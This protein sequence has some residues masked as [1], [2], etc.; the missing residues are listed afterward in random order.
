MTTND[1]APERVLDGIGATP[2]AGVGSAVWYDSSVAGSLSEP[3]DPGSVTPE[4][5]RERFREAREATRRELQAEREAIAERLGED[6]AEI[7]DAHREFLDDPQITEAVDGR[8]DEGLPAEHAVNHAF[9]GAIEQFEAAGGLAAERT[10]DL[11][12]VRN[13]LL[14]T[15]LGAEAPDLADLPPGSIVVA[16]RLG[17]ADTVQ[18]DPDRVAGF[19][20]ATGGR[21]SHAAVM[22]RSLGLPAVVGVGDE[23]TTVPDGDVIVVD[24]DDGVVVVNPTE[25]RQAAARQRRRRVEV[26]HG[27]VETSDGRPVEVAVNIGSAHEAEAALQQGA[28]GIGLFRTEFFF[29]DRDVPPSEAEQYDAFVTVLEAFD[30]ERV[31]VRTLDVGGDKPIPYLDVDP[32]TNPFLGTRGVRLA[33]GERPSL[34]ETQLRALVRA[35][36]TDPGDRLAVMFPLVASVPELEDIQS[37]LEAVA[38]ELDD[39][40]V[41]NRI[42]ELG[43]MVETPASVF[44]ARELAERVDF[45]SIGT[46]DLTQYVMAA[47]RDDERVDRLYDPLQPPVLRAIERTVRAG[48]EG[49]AWVGMCGEMAGEPDLTELLIGLGLDELSMSAAM[50][51][52]VK[53]AVMETDS[54]QA[55]RL[56]ERALAADSRAGIHALL[57]GESG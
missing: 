37:R 36:A 8:L 47:A 4:A 21:R 35:A 40:G 50:V 18:L 17:P 19:A 11:R 27:P 15:L 2:F 13:R 14:R 3:S 38:A 44:L 57:N 16:D 7:L 51:P 12:E 20:T 48:H 56:A 53:A 52:E 9:E 22:A 54:E 24:G 55:R 30:G 28:D 32:G 5:Q 42:P 34:F 6:E 26:R 49:G 41:P 33:P 45:L 31:V 1:D 43:V 10:D 46:N 23:L 39:E 25:T 29:L